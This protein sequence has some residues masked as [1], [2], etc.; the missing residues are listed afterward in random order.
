VTCLTCKSFDLMNREMA[1]VGYGHCAHSLAG[2]FN[3]IRHEPCEKFQSAE[4]GVAAKRIAWAN[5][6]RVTQ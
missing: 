3:S 4:P 6:R 1:K 5:S 2:S